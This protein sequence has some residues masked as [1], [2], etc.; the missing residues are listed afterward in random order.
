MEVEK[1]SSASPENNIFSDISPAQG[2]VT[3]GWGYLTTQ[4]VIRKVDCRLRK[5]F[6]FQI[7]L[8]NVPEGNILL[9]MA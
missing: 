7:G 3:A 5:R 2:K 9:N 1:S 4:Q 8:L 6:L